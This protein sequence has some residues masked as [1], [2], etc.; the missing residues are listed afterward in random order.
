MLRAEFDCKVPLKSAELL[1]TKDEGM[2]W[3]QRN[4]Q[5]QPML[6]SGSLASA[7]IPMGTV[8][9]YLNVT[10]ARGCTTSS[11]IEFMERPTR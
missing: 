7:A 9:C 6:L 8:A 10:D 2:P 1:F 5:A 3:P 4:W 11:E